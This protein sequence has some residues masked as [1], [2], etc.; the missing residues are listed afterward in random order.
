MGRPGATDDEVVEAAKMANCD[1]FIKKL[2]Q[3]YY[4]LIGENGSKLSGGERQRISIARAFL[5]NAPILLLDEISASLDVENERKIQESLNKLIAGKTVI[6]IS[7][8]LKS[9]EQVDKIVVMD[10]GQVD[11]VGTHGELL[12]ESSLYR[13]L[14][15]KSSLTE[16]FRY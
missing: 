6:I 14:I 11:A 2:P 10:D 9:I 12:G 15:E 8:R 3:S 16:E 4:T 5:K 7:H 1:E 13:K